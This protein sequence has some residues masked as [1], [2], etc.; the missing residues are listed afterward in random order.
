MF[1]Y[2]LWLELPINIRH[3]IARRFGVPKKKSV[4]VANN[5]VVDDG[6]YLKDL[7][8]G[9][10]LKSLQ[11]DLHS[12]IPDYA[13]LWEAL[14]SQVTGKPIEIKLPDNSVNVIIEPEKKEEVMQPDPN[15]PEVKVI[16][17]QFCLT[18]DSKGVRHKLTCPKYVPTQT[19]KSE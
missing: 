5:Q 9:L 11:E 17:S 19:K 1:P 2:L 3:E 14:V 10:T 8:D 7:S 13:T 18:C 4:H 6:Y 15:A 16:P 12:D